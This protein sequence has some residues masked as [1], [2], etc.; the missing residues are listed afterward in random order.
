[1]HDKKRFDSIRQFVQS[2]GYYIVAL[3]CVLAVGVSGFVYFRHGDEEAVRLSSGS[4]PQLVDEPTDDESTPPAQRNATRS[5]DAAALLPEPAQAPV[6]EDT[7]F[8]MIMPVE[9][10]LSQL[11]SMD[12]LSYN[13]TT[14]DWR[15]HD[16]IDILSGVGAEV[17]A[18]ADGTVASV[19]EDEALGTVLTVRHKDG[20]LTRY[21]NLDPDTAVSVGQEVRQG[22][23]VGYVGTSALMESGA[24]AHLH[25][26]LCCDAVSLNPTDYFAW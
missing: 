26:E 24:D 21:A 5:V 10:D 6:P 13:P 14:R 25:F 3:A 19:Y 18:A 2:K 11:Y 20:Y 15:T 7:A 1:M 17:R 23:A 22:D 16:G 9:G 4:V 12:H 8:T